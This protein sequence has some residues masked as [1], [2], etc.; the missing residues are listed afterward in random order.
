MSD[1]GDGDGVGATINVPLP[2]GSGDA[3]AL[4][5][6]DEIVAPRRRPIRAGYNFGI[7]RVRRA[8]AGSTRG[9]VVPHRDLPPAECAVT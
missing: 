5:A 9:L 7:S 2:P 6:F 3:A 8:L 4:A 1:A